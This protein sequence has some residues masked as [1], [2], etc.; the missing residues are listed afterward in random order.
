VKVEDMRFNPFQESLP[1]PNTNTYTY[2]KTFFILSPS[3]I[4][5]TWRLLISGQEYLNLLGSIQI[6][7]VSFLSLKAEFFWEEG[8]KKEK[9]FG[10]ERQHLKTPKRLPLLILSCYMCT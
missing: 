7:Q 8:E 9:S 3:I 6:T 1:C 4:L 10:G 2:I 5:K